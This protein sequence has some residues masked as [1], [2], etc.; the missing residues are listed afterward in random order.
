MGT[1][2]RMGPAF[3]PTVLGG[4][5]TLIGLVAIGRALVSAGQPVG[6]MAFA[7][8]G[9]VTLANV[10]FALL[11]RPLGLAASLIVL[12]VVSACA[13]GRFRWP[14][15]LALAAGLAAGSSILF[16]WLLGLPIRIVGTWLGG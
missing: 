9:L 16:V 12:V 4:L 13:S 15:A 2:M 5:L 3:F 14:V 7:K 10:L 1:A 11:L 8:L 6:R